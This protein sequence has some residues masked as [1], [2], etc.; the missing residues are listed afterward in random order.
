M[1]QFTLDLNKVK[2][3]KSIYYPME[4]IYSLKIKINKNIF[5]ECN[6]FILFRINLYCTK[7]I[8]SYLEELINSLTAIIP[9]E[10][11]SIF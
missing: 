3:N 2:H 7:I 11:L 5:R 1:E 6:L 8:E 9:N 4:K 10:W